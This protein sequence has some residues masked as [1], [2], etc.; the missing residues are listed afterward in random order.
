MADW[1]GSTAAVTGGRALHRMASQGRETMSVR[2]IDRETAP[3]ARN[4]STAAWLAHV[5]LAASL[6]YP[7]WVLMPT[8]LTLAREHVDGAVFSFM[9]FDRAEERP[10]ALW[11]DPINDAAYRGYLA[12]HPE[13]FMEYP[14]QQ[15]L[16]GRGRAI[17]ALERTPEYETG[18]MY[19][20][21]LRPL[22]VHWGMGV[23]VAMGGDGLGFVSVC[24]EREKGSYDDADWGLWDRFADC[25]GGLESRLNRWATLP[26]AD[27]RETTSSTLWLDREG[28][29]RTHGPMLRRLLFLLRHKG[30]GPPDWSR[31]DSSALPAEILPALASMFDEHA[32]STLERRLECDAGRFHFVLE[33]MQVTPEQPE[34]LVGVTIRHH[35][36]LDLIAARRL[37]GWPLSPQEKRILI[38]TARHASLAQMAGSLGIGLGT[39]KGY[40]NTLLDRFGVESRDALLARVLDSPPPDF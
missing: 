14:V 15:M 21:V 34:P 19:Q 11:I 39:L 2:K 17:R 38:A 7:S 20:C 4:R 6:P 3:G 37:W 33:R 16:E 35:E 12:G 1:H 8:L 36:P 40:N 9:W 28:R 13:I 24:R 25:L 26:C 18:P 31:C 32:P 30:L 29:L 5:R 27:F 10:T 23:P 22:G